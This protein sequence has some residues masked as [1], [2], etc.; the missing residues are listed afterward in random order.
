MKISV[1]Y[2]KTPLTKEETIKKIEETSADLLHV[3]L[4][5]GLFVDE[6]NFAW[7]EIWELL[8]NRKKPLDIHLMTLDV[9][10][11]IKNAR[12]L[13]PDY[14]TFQLEATRDPKECI[15]LI[16]KSGI[17]CGIAIK[18]ETEIEELVPFLNKLDL[19]L[20]LGVE[21]GRGG[22]KFIPKTIDKIKQLKEYQENYPFQIEVDGGINDKTIQI[23]QDYVD[24]VVSGSFICESDNMEESI[25]KLK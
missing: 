11:H 15:E 25:K 13:N 12:S 3:D 20:I 23:V 7:E 24:I 5:D 2:L 4:M 8:K 18:P 16:K 9:E 14:I 1:S 21:P 19:I 10:H 6:C 17:K 22:Q